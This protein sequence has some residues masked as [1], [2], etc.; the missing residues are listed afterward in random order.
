[1]ARR[2]RPRKRRISSWPSAIVVRD[3]RRTAGGVLETDAPF[4][5]ERLQYLPAPEMAPFDRAAATGGPRLVGR[6]GQVTVALVN[7][8]FGDPL[9]QLRLRHQRRRLLFGLGEG[10]RLPARIAHQVT[11]VFISHAHMDHIG[12]FLL[13]VRLRL[14]HIPACRLVG[15]PRPAGPGAPRGRAP[16]RHP[17]SA[18]QQPARRS[19]PAGQGDHFGLPSTIFGST[20]ETM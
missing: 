2:G 16:D 4:A 11:D 13:L 8:V 14:G 12:G 3:A 20:S 1:M 19:R 9:L 18:R 7:G 5:G 17:E 10:G 15:T 6:V